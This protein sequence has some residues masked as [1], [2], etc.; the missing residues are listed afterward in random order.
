ME[1][2]KAARK[3]GSG[4]SAGGAMAVASRPRFPTGGGEERRDDW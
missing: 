4:T 1:R 2:T 3:T